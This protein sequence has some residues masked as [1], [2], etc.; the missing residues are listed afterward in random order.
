M[1]RREGDEKKKMKRKETRAGR[2]GRKGE[3]KKYGVYKLHYY[4]FL[5]F[6][7]EKSVTYMQQYIYI[8]IYV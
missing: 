5:F 2:T 6:H 7:F 3:I 1:K 4:S 8:Y